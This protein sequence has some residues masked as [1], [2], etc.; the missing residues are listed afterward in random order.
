[1]SAGLSSI[2]CLLFLLC[3]VIAF[4]ARA[5]YEVEEEKLLWLRALL[6]LRI[7]RGPA[8]SSWTD[9][10]NGRMRYG[11]RSTADGFERT[12][13]FALAQLAIQGGA[14][15]PWGLRAQAQINVQPD[16]ADDYAPQLTEAIVRKEW[17]EQGTGWGLQAGLMSAPFSLERVGPAWTPEYSI[18]S[19]ALDSWLWEEIS[20]AGVEGEWW[21]EPRNGPR[22][23][24]VMGLGYGPDQLGR[25]LALR[26]WAMGDG[27]S[28][29]NSDLPLPNGTR[30][31]IF[32]ER[33]H[34]PAAYTLISVSDR[35][36]R[37]ALK[38]GYFDNRGDQ[39]MKGVWHTRFTTAGA[40]LHPAPGI[41]VVMQYLSGKALVRDTLND[42]SLRAFYALVSYRRR[43]HRYS[44][45]YDEFRINDLDGGNSTRE[46][47]DAVTLAYTYEWGLRQRVAVEYAS[48]SGNRLGRT[49]SR[50]AQDGWQL[51]YRFRY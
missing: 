45:R 48:L 6:D 8:V 22:L 43:S 17:Q 31:D 51:S 4:P 40:V 27:I 16:I 39:S 10:G 24:V 29:L 50:L 18:S 9:R 25:L 21:H 35:R 1:M 38:L 37:G 33:D 5:Q 2:S 41:D 26:G 23:G 47:G 19:S 7:A 46:R 36:E 42:S 3:C 11:G 13:R 14:S 44:V 30:T 12:T 15:L 32:D 20:L 34:R 28:G 49:Q